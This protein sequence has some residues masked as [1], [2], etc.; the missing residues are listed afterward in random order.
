MHSCR[1]T[2]EL[3]QQFAEA[4]EDGSMKCLPA[5]EEAAAFGSLLNEV[6]EQVPGPCSTVC[7]TGGSQPLLP[8]PAL[9]RRGTPK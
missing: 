3:D 5:T 7:L 8:P 4:T 1:G 9:S 6:A 2:V